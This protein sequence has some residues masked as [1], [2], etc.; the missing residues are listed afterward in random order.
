MTTVPDWVLIYVVPVVAAALVWVGKRYLPQPMLEL[1]RQ[2][3]AAIISELG[4][5]GRSTITPAELADQAIA[6][7][8]GVT[9]KQA[10]TK[11][12]DRAVIEARKLL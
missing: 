6:R 3:L 2:A 12:A 4:S 9:G 8:E 1:V 11:L 7:V 5:Q 10:S